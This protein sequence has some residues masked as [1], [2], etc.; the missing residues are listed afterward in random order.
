MF[1]Q[2]QRALPKTQINLSLFTARPIEARAPLSSFENFKLFT[3]IQLLYLLCPFEETNKLKSMLE[4]AFWV[5]K[6]FTRLDLFFSIFKFSHVRLEVAQVVAHF[7]LVELIKKSFWFWSI[8]LSVK[9]GSF[10]EWRVKWVL[11]KKKQLSSLCQDFSFKIHKQYFKLL[12]QL[13]S[14][15]QPVKKEK[16]KS[17][18]EDLRIKNQPFRF[19]SHFLSQINKINN[20]FAKCKLA[21][22]LAS[23]E[24]GI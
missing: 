6:Y 5:K 7:R 10:D 11:S 18:S 17:R 16:L 8:S 22:F 3:Q 13:L 23:H 19:A 9:W 14:S 15:V 21:M 1:F 4:G 12:Y 2:F 24:A 20:Q